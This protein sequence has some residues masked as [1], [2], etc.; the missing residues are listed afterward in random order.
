[1][2]LSEL[3]DSALKEKETPVC[4]GTKANWYIPAIA[5][6]GAFLT[7]PPTVADLSRETINGWID[8]RVGESRLSCYTVKTRRGA[9]L[10]LWRAANDL[11]LLRDPPAKIRKVK[12]RQ[13]NPTAWHR[14][15]VQRL[16]T[17]VLFE[18]EPERF[19]KVYLPSDLY[20]GS[21]IAAAYDSALRLG[22][23][24]SLEREWIRKGKDGAGLIRIQQSKTERLVSCRFNPPT[25]ELIDR[26]MAENPSRRLI[27]PLWCRRECF[28]ERFKKLVRAAG[29]RQGT[30]RYLRR[31]S[32]T[33]IEQSSPG[34][35]YRHAGHADP[36][37]TMKH[38]LDAEQLGG[39][40]SPE[41]LTIIR[42]GSRKR[43][44]SVAGPS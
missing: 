7:R 8:Q 43:R 17:F 21:L 34:T 26:L 27:W 38:Y 39:A 2:L 4:N 12:I 13:K 16:L 41:P 11:D 15:E 6:L 29:I 37:T 1:M 28:Y 33:H 40:V 19:D 31:A 25:M 36:S 14:D 44:R 5:D 9:I 30:F 10:A 3:L 35:S 24:L 23:L 20:W 32:A 18:C 22:D 42:T